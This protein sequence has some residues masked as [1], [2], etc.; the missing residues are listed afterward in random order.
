[1][2]DPLMRRLLDPPLSRM[3]FWLAQCGLT[4]NSVTGFAFVCGL[5]AACAV[6]TGAHAIGLAL[7]LLGRLGDGLDGAVARAARPSDFGGYLD[8]IGDLIA[9]G[10]LAAAFGLSDPTFAAPALVL[11]TSFIATASTFLAYGIIAAKRGIQSQARGRKSFFHAAG[12]AEGTETIFFFSL[13]LFWPTFFP[14][15]AYGF[16]ALCFVTA[17]FRVRDAH[18][19]FKD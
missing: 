19:L 18:A 5:G 13:V 8:I 7:F 11:L 3:G 12:L 14:V 6:Y 17:F 9:Y 15:L 4:P 2:L 10:A 16:A 1:M